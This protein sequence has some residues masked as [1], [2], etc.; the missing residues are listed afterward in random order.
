MVHIYRVCSPI[1]TLGRAPDVVELTA[2]LANSRETLYKYKCKATNIVYE[3]L[4]TMC[5]PPKG[6]NN[7]NSLNDPRAEPAIY[8]GE[9]G[10]ERCG[11][12]AGRLRGKWQRWKQG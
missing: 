6:K 5:N 1:K 3:S 9:S 11:T 2:T 12:T 7:L 10:T 8:V 4:C